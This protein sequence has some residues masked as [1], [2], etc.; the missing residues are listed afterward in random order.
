MAVRS[1]TAR[2]EGSLKE[3]AGRIQLESDAFNGPFSFKSRFEDGDGTNPEE[4]IAAAH[5]GCFSMALAHGLSELG[6]K[7]DR[8]ETSAKVHLKKGN[9]GFAISRIELTTDATV[10]G[11]NADEFRRHAE[12]AKNDCPASKALSGTRIVLTTQLQTP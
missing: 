11:I 2:W 9:G 8:I 12:S 5:A 3:G 6:H 4:L 10:P 7:P 1:A